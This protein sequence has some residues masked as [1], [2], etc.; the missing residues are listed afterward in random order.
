MSITR[1]QFA[2]EERR[3]KQLRR[4]GRT[5]QFIKSWL[6]GWRMVRPTRR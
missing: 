5:E 1:K 6:R 3:M 4:E 2:E